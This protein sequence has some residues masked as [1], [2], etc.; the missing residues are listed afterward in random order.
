M[1]NLRKS[2]LAFVAGVVFLILTPWLH[3]K[4]KIGQDL[5]LSPQLDAL[6]RHLHWIEFDEM[7]KLSQEFF[8][9]EVKSLPNQQGYFIHHPYLK[10]RQN[11]DHIEIQAQ[12]AHLT[13]NSDTIQLQHQVLIHRFNTNQEKIATIKTELLNYHPKQKLAETSTLVTFEFQDSFFESQGLK[14]FFE[15]EKYIQ[16]SKVKGQLEPKNLKHKL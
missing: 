11:T 9:P 12:N 1:S 2:F 6:V 16:L 4:P 8:A 13:H 10:L 15:H 14:V 7:G 5:R 3:Q